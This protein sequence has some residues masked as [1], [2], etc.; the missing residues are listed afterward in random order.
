MSQLDPLHQAAIRKQHRDLIGL[1]RDRFEGLLIVYK[2]GEIPILVNTQDRKDTGHI[3]EFYDTKY[4]VEMD[5]R[6]SALNLPAKVVV[7]VSK[8]LDT[9]FYRHSN[10]EQIVKKTGPIVTVTKL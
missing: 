6:L 3:R 9:Q 2:P 10:P 4:H 5:Q 8:G 7:E 1:E